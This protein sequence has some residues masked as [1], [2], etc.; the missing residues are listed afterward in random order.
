MR[1][2][3]M[4]NSGNVGKSTL[5]Q[6]M[7]I[8][9]IENCDLLRVETLN[10]DGEASGEKMG[11]DDFDKIFNKILSSE[12]EN[13]IV[14]VGSSNIELFRTKI[15]DEFAGAHGFLD[16]YL[17]PVT[18]DEKQQNDTIA[19][20]IDLDNMGVEH[21]KI[22][23][24]FN[25][26][27]PKRSISEQFSTLFESKNLKLIGFDLNNNSATVAETSL[28]KTLDRAKLKYSEV[29]GMN[30]DFDSL[31]ASASGKEKM[32]LE[33]EKFYRLGYESY[34][35]NLQTAFDALDLT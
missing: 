23:L 18:P 7:L 15:Q 12:Y 29:Q 1:I 21:E 14:D 19:T 26:A 27:K 2:I 11:A 4:N 13:V 28:F 34:Q 3:V 9:R 25:R 8:N 20:I 32:T 17:I 16:Y 35:S 24:I 22:K 10:S 5:C 33:L 30:K 31:I 6:H